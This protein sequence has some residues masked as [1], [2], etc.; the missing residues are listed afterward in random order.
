MKFLNRYRTQY[1]ITTQLNH[2]EYQSIQNNLSQAQNENNVLTE[3]LLNY[4]KTKHTDLLK[5]S[6]QKEA[7]KKAFYSFVIDEKAVSPE[8]GAIISGFIVSIGHNERLMNQLNK[9]RQ[10]MII[11]IG[12]TYNT[13]YH[14]IDEIDT[15][16]NFPTIISLLLIG[17]VSNVSRVPLSFSPAVVSVAG[18]VADTVIAIIINKNA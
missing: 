2:E 18:Y 16:K 11:Y 9:I 8:Y 3:A 17:K 14:I 10:G 5:N 12:L 1:T 15:P 6:A 4:V 7:L 13:E